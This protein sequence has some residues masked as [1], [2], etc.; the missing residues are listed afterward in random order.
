[1]DDTKMVRGVNMI[2]RKSGHKKHTVWTKC[3]TVKYK[4]KKEKENLKFLDLS[5]KF[6]RMGWEFMFDVTLASVN[7]YFGIGTNAP[8][9]RLTVHL[10]RVSRMWPQ[11][12]SSHLGLSYIMWFSGQNK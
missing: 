9:F 8:E 6:K 1:M 10:I 4:K 12:S 11:Q 3:S 7:L 2:T 5:A